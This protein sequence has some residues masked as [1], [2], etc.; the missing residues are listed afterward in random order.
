MLTQRTDQEQSPTGRRRWPARL[1]QVATAFVATALL[2][3][4]ALIWSTTA[5]PTPAEAAAAAALQLTAPEVGP[6]ARPTSCAGT[7]V[8]KSD[9][10]DVKLRDGKPGETF[11]LESGLHRLVATAQPQ[12][13][14]TIVGDFGIGGVTRT[15]VSGAKLFP[16]TTTPWQA[17]DSTKGPW[18][19]GGQT[20]DPQLGGSRWN[21]CQPDRPMCGQGE[22]LFINDVPL[23]PV[24]SLAK[25]EPGTWFFDYATDRVYLGSNPITG[26]PKVEMSVVRAAFSSTAANVTIDNMVVEKFAGFGHA[27]TIAGKLVGPDKV[28]GEN[29]TVKHSEV[30]LNHGGG[31]ALDNGGRALNNYVH[32]NGQQ[33]I[34]GY[35]GTNTEV[36]SNEIAYNNTAG[37]QFATEG[38]AGKFSE[39]TGLTYKNNYVHD[40]HGMGAWTD[41][42][43]LGAVYENNIVDDND[44]AGIMHE[45]SFAA[46]IKNNLVRGNGRAW[47]SH[48]NSGIFVSS[49]RDVQVT[50]NTV[51][52]GPTSGLTGIQPSSRMGI[53]V[54]QGYRFETYC[55]GPPNGQFHPDTKKP[56]LGCIARN[57]NVQDNTIEYTSRLHYLGAGVGYN[58]SGVMKDA[59]TPQQANN[60]FVGNSYVAPDCAEDRW[61]WVDAGNASFR[62]GFARWQ[63]AGNDP[64]GS[65][66]KNS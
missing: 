38:G 42:A 13:G 60:T 66:R 5:T 64:G 11:C 26:S 31:I 21:D 53:T 28:G 39:T 23:R 63:Q 8:A 24:N 15:T 25:V 44:G 10:L 62:G 61:F 16:A 7:P 4:T 59:T 55:D 32:H 33:G 34:S 65:C 50:G 30:R 2:G 14:Q 46:T 54:L 6:Q 12:A 35:R 56:Y 9:R 48:N 29:W 37:F 1:P 22:E 27:A 3:A 41:G 51:L 52:V 18:W 40:N 17:I 19:V 36:L 45:I 47:G 20:E 57:N 43:N 58:G 49:S